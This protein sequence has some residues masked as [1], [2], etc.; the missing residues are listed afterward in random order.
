VLIGVFAFSQVMTESRRMGGAGHYAGQVDS[1]LSFTS[2]A[3]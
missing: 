1:A 2:H 3:R